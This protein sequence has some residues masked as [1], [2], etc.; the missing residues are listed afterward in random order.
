M[1]KIVLFT[2]YDN[3]ALGIRLLGAYLE[4]HGHECSLIFFKKYAMK[5]I[6]YPREIPF[7]YEYGGLG[8]FTGTGYDVDPWSLVE[9]DLL[10]RQLADLDP[11][12]IGL[13]TRNFL[14]REIVGLLGRIKE[15]C[16]GALLIGGGF[17]PTFTPEVYL[18]VCDY[19]VLGEGEEAILEIAE[20]VDSG[21]PDQ[22]KTLANVAYWQDGAVVKNP[23][24][25]LVTDFTDI[26]HPKVCKPGIYHIHD[27][28][29]DD[30]DELK[31]V[32]NIFFGRGCPSRCSYC[33]AGQLAELHKE[34]GNSSRGYRQRSIVDVISELR[35]AKEMGFRNIS[36]V[37]S[38]LAAPYG[39]VKELLQR[40]R[41]EIR[42]PLFAHFHPKMALRHPDLIELACEGGLHATVVGV[43]SG[44]ELFA[45][46]VYNRKNRNE[47]LL[48]FARL[49]ATYEGISIQ[50]HFIFANP[51][52]TEQSFRESLDFIGMLAR[53]PA[54]RVEGIGVHR[55]NV[56]PNTPIARM[57]EKKGCPPATV[58]DWVYQSQLACL[59]LHQNDADFEE[60][61]SN[62]EYERDVK[63]LLA[64]SGSVLQRERP[65]L[66]I[67]PQ[68]VRE[69]DGTNPIRRSLGGELGKAFTI[70][71][72]LR[73][74]PTAG[75]TY[76]MNR[77]GP[78]M[79]LLALPLAIYQLSANRYS[80]AVR[81]GSDRIRVQLAQISA[82]HHIALQVD[83][84]GKA[85]LFI[86]GR[87]AREIRSCEGFSGHLHLGAGY[88]ERSWNGEMA[89]ARVSAGAVYDEDFEPAAFLLP[90]SETVFQLSP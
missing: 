70:E 53:D 72:L 1:A 18:P 56:F 43:Q 17:G 21:N 77:V 80:I 31:G 37:D 41:D 2:A 13:S 65:P 73:A 64:K 10:C 38:Y 89:Y 75:Q 76:E 81:R 82:W 51:L 48:D 30:T 42:L 84:E 34:C 60:V 25:P 47:T 33:C 23:L 52:E 22:T 87:R 28:E 63:K 44:S 20:N 32:Y 85:I 9:E 6:D 24:R 4:K 86:D 8:A 12:I 26:P 16:P 79:P 5:R 66:S 29:I 39:V 74:K 11:D 49:L 46:E 69:F 57:I 71:V 67:Q 78:P 36:F 59:R 55:L 19:V 61:F 58:D 50:Y 62:K 45:R 90:S 27:N 54:I 14:D 35:E 68:K 83:E 3:F 40:Y 7:N 88:M 15:Q